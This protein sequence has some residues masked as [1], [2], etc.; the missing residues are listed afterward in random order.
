VRSELD[1]QGDVQTVLYWDDTAETTIDPVSGEADFEGYR[2]YRSNPGDDRAGDIVGAASLIAQYDKPGNRT[3]FNNGLEPIRLDTPVEIE[4]QTYNYRFVAD[5]LLSGWQYAFAVTAFDVGDIDAGL[6]SFESARTANAVRVFP[7]T[8]A[9]AEGTREVGVYPNPYRL[10]AAWDGDT[11]RT[12]RLNFYNLPPRAEI[13]IYTTAG[14]IVDRLDHDSGSYQGDIRWF[15]TFSG[16]ERV[17]AGGEHAWDVLSNANLN[18]ATGLY[19]YSVRDLDT[20][21]VQTGRFA[22]I[23]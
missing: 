6:P 22:L 13:R 11:N 7:G 20:G 2:I 3:G 17:V 23:K 21:R 10:S 4:G 1:A 5:D 18:V 19:L 15:D 14:E 16:P 12:R 9:D 8:P